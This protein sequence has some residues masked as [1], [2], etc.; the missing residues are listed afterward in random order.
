MALLATA[1]EGRYVIEREIGNGGTAVVFRA[2]DLRHDR[3]VAIKVLRPGARPLPG[4]RAVPARDPHRGQPHAS[5]HPAGARQRGRAADLLYYVMPYVEGE[6]LRSRLIRE[7]AL[8]MDDAL[9]IA[10]ETADALSYAHSRGVV[11]RDIKPGN[12]L[13]IGG[14]AVVADFG[15]ATA[16]GIGMDDETLTSPGL[17]IGTPAYMSPEQARGELVVDGRSDLYSLGCV[18][19]EMLTGEPPFT[20]PSAHAVLTR[21]S[22]DIPEPVR[23]RRA[24]VPVEVEVAV[25]RLLEKLPARPLQHGGAVRRGIAGRQHRADR[26]ATPCGRFAP[27]ERHRG[28][29]GVDRRRGRGASAAEGGAR[30]LPLCRAAVPP[31]GRNPCAATQRRP[32]RIAV[33]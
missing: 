18:L 29:V 22:Q 32:V 2:R 5:A 7:G 26:T 19:Y 25:D 14:H 17:I 27:V 28:S 24:S 21:H 3:L 6:S 8:P 9:R 11:H 16:T 10:R 33:A 4:H 31:P 20:G 1:L 15:I 13:L 12:I 30:R 23:S